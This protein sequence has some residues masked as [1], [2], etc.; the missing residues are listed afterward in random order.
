MIW[1]RFEND[2]AV[3][4]SIYNGQTWNP[5]SGVTPKELY[6]GCHAIERECRGL[7]RIIAKTRMYKY[8][9]ENAQLDVREADFFPERLRHDYIISRIREEWI[10]ELRSNVINDTLA[11]HS[12]AQEGLCYTG[13]IDL[14]HV[15]P[16]WQSLVDLGF[17]GLLERVK[18][19]HAKEGLTEEQNTF[20]E[21]VESVLESTITLLRR[22]ANEMARHG[23]D[24]AKLVSESLMNLTVSAPKTLL[25]AM[26]LC[27]I[28]YNL[29]THVEREPIRSVGGLD[30]LFI[31]FYKS[32]LESG[33]FTEAQLR[34]LFRYYFYKF[35]SMKVVAN[36]PFYLGGRLADG[37]SGI[38]ELSYIIVE[39]YSALNIN[40]PKIHVRWYDEMPEDFVK[41]VM[42]SIRDGK[43]SFVFVNDNVIE[44]ALVGIG[45]DKADARNYI[46]IG[47]YEPCAMGKEIPCTCAGRANMTKA[48]LTVMTEGV[49]AYT[50]KAVGSVR[51]EA[52]S[53]KTFD[54]FYAAVKEQ[55][56]AF[57]DGAM[58][59][60]CAYEEHYPSFSQAPLL[61]AT[62]EPCVESGHDAYDRGAKY[63]NSSIVAFSV[64]T[65]A[66]ALVAVKRLVYDEKLLTLSE[67]AKILEN[68]WEGHEALHRRVLH[69]LPKYGNG[70][71]EPDTFAKEIVDF[72]AGYVN[73]KPN[74][75]GGV[76][77]LGLFSIDY[78]ISFGERMGATPDGRV[79]GEM[80]S[81]NMGAVTAM[82]KEGVTALINTVT[83]IDYTG[84][85]DGTV[86]DVML[87]R[88]ATEGDEGIVAMYALLTTY[89]KKGGFA[90]Q[91]NVLSP[92]VLRRAQAEP[93]KYA[94][95]QVRLCG[96]NVYF[97]ELSKTEQDDLIRQCENV[98][99]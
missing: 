36:V 20:Y 66:D 53:Y 21:C 55:I 39:E 13:N 9:L 2:R 73:G 60:V 12:S 80:L 90:F 58:D 6:D 63:S 22:L 81:K 78:R 34:E 28:Y 1:E 70:L 74:K 23:T 19:A 5:D 95:L 24:R 17:V 25:E 62:Y 33:R 82:D 56:A 67:F 57:L 16:D 27:M 37:S 52:D 8:V 42:K 68:N 61:S 98:A 11:L 89:M 44:K 83:K 35:Y 15:A 7:P 71:A 31:R 18:N 65:T 84:V 76:F 54:E 69:K 72:A 91:M 45:E 40:D 30:R 47:C 46:V 49:D 85:P 96:W 29:Q 50:G 3:L 88:T 43:N 51:A 64:A 86:L 32:D 94:T 59:L 93:E 75:R 92:D 10:K 41:L 97:V 14:G 77:R 99:G 79:A 38:N 48:L 26:Q 4:E 87:H